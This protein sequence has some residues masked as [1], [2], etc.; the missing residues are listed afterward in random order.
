M[1]QTMTT[2]IMDLER[3]KMCWCETCFGPPYKLYIITELH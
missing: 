1:N 2:L 3:K